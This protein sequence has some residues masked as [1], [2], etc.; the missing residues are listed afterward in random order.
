[1]GKYTQF[2]EKSNNIIMMLVSSLIN[3]YTYYKYTKKKVKKYLQSN[4]T[5]AVKYCPRGLLLKV[6]T[7]NIMVNKIQTT[8][9]VLV[10][11]Y[12]KESYKNR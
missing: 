2:L 10:L 8:S 9:A 11:L 1:M 3:G 4:I 6:I 7:H 12:E 5:C